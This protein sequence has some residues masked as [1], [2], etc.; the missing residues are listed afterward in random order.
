MTPGPG[1]LWLEVGGDGRGR[2]EGL[3][4]FST[5]VDMPATAHRVQNGDEDGRGTDLSSLRTAKTEESGRVSVPVGCYA[6]V[7][8]VGLKGLNLNGS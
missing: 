4:L 8:R 3:R 2:R 1:G 5:L 7:S 6:T